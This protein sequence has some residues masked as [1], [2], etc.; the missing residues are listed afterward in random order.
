[1]TIRRLLAQLTVTDL[2]PAVAWYTALFGRGPDARPMAGLVEWHL[3]DTY[4]V[5]VWA[6][7]DRAG[8]STVVLDESDLDAR[9]ARLTAAGIDHGGARPATSSR[10]LPVTDPDGNRIVFT[11]R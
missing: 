6:E 1:M 4:G 2:D 7:P 5:Q 8:H 11:G 10:I 9:L 3:A